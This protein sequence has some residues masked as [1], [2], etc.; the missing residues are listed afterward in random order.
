MRLGIYRQLLL[1]DDEYHEE[2][3]LDELEGLEMHPAILRCNKKIHDEAASVLY[4]ENTFYFMLSG[5]EWIGLWHPY[6]AKY[7]TRLSRRYS[8]LI[9]K[10]F[11]DL[12]LAGSDSD[13]G[14]YAVLDAIAILR[15]NI[16]EAARKLALNDLTLL[17]IRFRNAY[18]G[19]PLCPF[20]DGWS[21]F[22]GNPFGG[23]ECLM[24][25]LKIRATRVSE[26][27]T[28]STAIAVA[29]DSLGLFLV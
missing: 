18:T 6:G 7:K 12:D 14:I 13:P 3:N 21:R 25:L 26:Q 1:V 27:T 11:L 2:I 8:R 23:Q 28:W 15:S 17:K 19:G 10:V 4:G 29:T 16:D 9:T 20:R 22:G 24:P 5:R